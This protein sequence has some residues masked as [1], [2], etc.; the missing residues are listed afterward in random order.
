MLRTRV[1]VFSLLGDFDINATEFYHEVF[2]YTL[3]KLY[4]FSPLI[5][6]SLC[7]VN[8]NINCLM[9]NQAGICGVNSSW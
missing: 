3:K 1:C 8:N 6:Y 4:S 9:L 7:Y 2:P 5:C